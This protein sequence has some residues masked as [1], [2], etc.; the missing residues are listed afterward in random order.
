MLQIASFLV[1]AV[2]VAAAYL[3]Y[4]DPLYPPVIQ[5]SLWLTVLCIFWANESEFYPLSAGVYFIFVTG[6]VLFALG[7]F[8]ATYRFTPP[9]HSIS[10]RH[11]RPDWFASLLFW[12]P[13]LGF[14]L[15]LRRALELTA[16]GLTGFFLVDL[17]FALQAKGS[18]G[19]LDYLSVL[20]LA[21]AVVHFVIVRDRAGRLRFLVAAATAAGYGILTTGRSLLLFLI[22]SIL[23][24]ALITRRVRVSRALLAGGVAVLV[25]FIGLGIALGKMG[26]LQL[27]LS[28]RAAVVWESFRLYLLGSLP[29]FDRFVR[30]DVSPTYGANMFRSAIAALARLGLVEPPHG[31]VQPFVKVPEPTNVYTVFQPYFG[32]FSYFGACFVPFFLGLLHG[33][34]F[35]RATRGTPFWV[36]AYGLLLYPLC[37]QFFQD[38]YFN[39]LSTWAQLAL[40][41]VFYFYFSRGRSVRA[42]IAPA[43]TSR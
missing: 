34:V 2:T 15:M 29:A 7:A 16:H 42:Q 13:I 5:A 3:R 14:P 21:S 33:T 12:T 9:H 26:G 1:L 37:M 36:V 28:E 25:M 31:L 41:L 43:P 18:Y 6:A 30:S 38:Q 11:D 39:L 23:G 24:I 22:L 19:W 17:R 35:R 10:F 8:L 27:T 20:A 4:R 32:D 40:W